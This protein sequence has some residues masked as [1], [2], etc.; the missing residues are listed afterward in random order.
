MSHNYHPACG[1]SACC[2]E[3]LADERRDEYIED[4]SPAVAKSVAR[5]AGFA[6]TALNDLDENTRETVLADVGNFW[7]EFT[8]S[9]DEEPDLAA[10]G[11]RLWR[12]LTPHIE[13]AA[14][15]A[16]RERVAAD[17]DRSEAA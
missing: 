15:E 1:C 2:D 12:L 6:A 7:T 3:E 8:A 13:A 10:V 11:A 9:K 5:E 4:F 14:L 17:Y 16:A